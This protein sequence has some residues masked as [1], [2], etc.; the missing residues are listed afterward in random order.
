MRTAPIFKLFL[1]FA[2]FLTAFEACCL[3][4]VSAR[5]TSNV[6]RESAAIPERTRVLHSRNYFY[7]GGTYNTTV[8]DAAA[9]SSGQMY[10]EHLVPQ[11]VTRKYPIVMIH[12]NGMTGT[13]FL[14]TP[15]GRPGWTDFFLN[16]GYELYIVDQPSRARSPWQQTIDGPQYMVDTVTVEQRFTATAKYNMWPK[17]S[18]HTQ[19]P[20]N[21]TRGDK[22][23][24]DFYRTIVPA[25]SSNVEASQKFRPVGAALLD[26]IGPAIIMT[27]SQSGQNGWPLADDRPSLVKAIIAIEPV[28]PPFTNAIF[29]PIVPAR[30]YGLTEVSMTFSP[31]IQSASDIETVVVSSSE[32][33]TCIQQASPP[34]KLVN[35]ANIPVLL[36]TSETGYH[37]VYDDCIRDFLTD[38]GVPVDHVN[39]G[40]VGIHGNGHM[41]FMEENRFEIA[42]KVLHKWLEEK[43]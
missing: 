19:W 9:I 18:L 35:L 11:F 38:A 16:K 40:D 2:S 42:E 12:G 27:H 33:Y 7:V 23:F 21:G 17:A 3:Q 10:V 29:P 24:D 39:L 25:L 31:P 15:D 8:A 26:R 1:L 20:G 22:I 5:T 32:N 43:L 4:A 13:N 34:R 28:G 6:R 36:V 41:M 37:T 30:P 14:N